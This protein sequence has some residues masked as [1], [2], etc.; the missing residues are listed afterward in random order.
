MPLITRQLLRLAVAAMLCTS[1]LLSQQ[2]ST[3]E[4]QLSTP[5][6]SQLLANSLSAMGGPAS[7]LHDITLQGTVEHIAGSTDETGSIHLSA[8]KDGS[9]KVDVTLPSGSTSESVIW[10]ISTRTGQKRDA[11]DQI[12]HT[13]S[14]NLM[15]DAAWFSPAL[16][17]QH[18]A[19]YATLGEVVSSQ[20]T[21]SN[22]ESA[23]QLTWSWHLQNV[24]A[25][26]DQEIQRLSRMELVL[27]PNTSLPR[28]LYY[29]THSDTN[30][31]INIRI[32]VRY[33][34]YQASNGILVPMHLERYVN[35]TLLYDIHISSAELNSGLDASQFQLQ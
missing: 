28:T 16:L 3:S 18:A 21:G 20:T 4:P 15:T 31:S 22:G 26:S 19:F 8:I 35:G 11:K 29:E 9:S 34:D 6:A 23:P 13:A 24:K 32:E 7:T 33:S 14:H 10:S 17:V 5:S 12:H 1:C 2:P 27:D 30:S 25:G